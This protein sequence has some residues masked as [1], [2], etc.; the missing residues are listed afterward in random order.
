MLEL[1]KNHC[2]E[3]DHSIITLPELKELIFESEACLVF[4]LIY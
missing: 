1:M 4:Y 2:E 3:N